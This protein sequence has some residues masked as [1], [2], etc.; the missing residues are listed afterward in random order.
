MSFA[1]DNYSV[2]LDVFQGPLDLLLYLIRKEEV[3]IY[4]IPAARITEQYLK[5]V[6]MLK[7][8]NL[9]NAGD[10]ILM[11]ATLI[12]IKA[13]MLLPRESL[14][15]DELDPREEL[16]KAL[17][18]Y[19]KY[20]EASEILYEKRIDESRLTAVYGHGNGYKN[21]ETILKNNTSLF[22]LLNAFHDVMEAFKEDDSYLVNHDDITVED[23]IEVILKMLAEKEFA[24][25]EDLFSD[26]RVKIIAIM[27]FLAILEMT[28]HH[29][30]KIRQSV[31]FAEIR[32]YPTDRIQQTIAL[33]PIE[34]TSM[35]GQTATETE[36]AA[37]E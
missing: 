16:T 9:E 33:P 6:E 10:Y 31:A 22:E 19:R 30:I 27:T 32:I 36:K 25:F 13:Q 24:T 29:R 20:R 8:L 37:S 5:Y 35:S 1:E 12:R 28:K 7:L 11:A 15:D 18:E 21:G 23:R 3:E 4:D 26:I 14:D 34:V 2:E 17:F